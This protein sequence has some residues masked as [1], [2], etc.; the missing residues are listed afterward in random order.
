MLQVRHFDS[1]Y[2]LYHEKIKTSRVFIRDCSMVSVYPLVLFG[3][4]QVNVQLQRGEFVVSLDDG[5]IRFA[6][7]SHQVRTDP[8]CESQAMKGFGNMKYG[9]F[10]QGPRTTELVKSE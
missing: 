2:L 9:A 6:A 8:S 4:G 3:G 10:L 5:W 7:A 1:P